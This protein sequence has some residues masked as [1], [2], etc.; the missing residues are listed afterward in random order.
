MQ[1][2]SLLFPFVSPFA[3]FLH[4]LLQDIHALPLLKHGK[5]WVVVVSSTTFSSAPGSVA[6][7]PSAYVLSLHLSLGFCS[8]E[9]YP[10]FFGGKFLVRVLP[11][12]LLDAVS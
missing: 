7:F 11:Q 6:V 4:R 5:S 12:L 8:L 10:S 3:S 2:A 9:Y 1:L